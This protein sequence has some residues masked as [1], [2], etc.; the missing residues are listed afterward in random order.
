[1]WMEDPRP[2]HEAQGWGVGETGSQL[3]LVCYDC[4]LMV[5]VTYLT[6]GA[7]PFTRHPLEPPRL[8]EEGREV[9]SL[10]DITVTVWNHP[11]LGKR[12]KHLAAFF[13]LFR[14]AGTWMTNERETGERG[15]LAK[16]VS[17]AEQRSFPAGTGSVQAS[18]DGRGQDSCHNFSQ[19]LFDGD[20][21]VRW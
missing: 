6:R 13:F 4:L 12:R 10:V 11:D 14:V 21:S 3:S 2:A 8:W 19:L 9:L 5:K 18:S 1:M 16:Q 15:R 17:K 7:F 20:G